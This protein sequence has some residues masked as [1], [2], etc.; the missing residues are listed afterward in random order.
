M[1]LASLQP[2]TTAQICGEV[3]LDPSAVVAPGVLLQ[4]DSG[5]KITIGAGVCL[6]MGT[7]VHA[8]GGKITIEAGA[9]LGAGVLVVGSLTIGQGS[10]IGATS[11]IYSKDIAPGQML[12]PGSLVTTEQPVAPSQP[13]PAPPPEA[14]AEKQTMTYGQ[15]QL[16]RLMVKIFPHRQNQL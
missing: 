4:A 16:N 9:N 8:H 11:T 15:V 5:C 13:P 14:E 2:L 7:I 6:G 12:A 1:Y 10:C 3:E